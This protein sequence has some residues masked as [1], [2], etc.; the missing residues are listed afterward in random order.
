MAFGQAARP[1]RFEQ[2]GLLLFRKLAKQINQCL[3]RFPGLRSKARN[4]IAEIGAIELRILAD[5]AR[6]EAFAERTEWNESDSEFF[7]R[8]RISASGPRQNREYSL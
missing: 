7:E 2:G 4:D 1:A 5:L 8:R 3:I 6:E